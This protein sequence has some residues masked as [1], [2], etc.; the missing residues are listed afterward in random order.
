MAKQE[1]NHLVN[2]RELLRVGALLPTAGL[3]GG[4]AFAAGDRTRGETIEQAWIEFGG[5]EPVDVRARMQSV[6]QAPIDEILA[7][8]VT[9]EDLPRVEAQLNAR[10]QGLI[11]DYCLVEPRSDSDLISFKPVL[12]DAE[13]D[14]G[15]TVRGIESGETSI[16]GARM[17]TWMNF[18][19]YLS[20]LESIAPSRWAGTPR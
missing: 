16:W 11:K 13:I 17:E 1:G 10:I 4:S 2:R 18:A 6:V 8:D 5:V 3:L 9:V 12:L 15:A 20:E 19:R 7:D 14:I